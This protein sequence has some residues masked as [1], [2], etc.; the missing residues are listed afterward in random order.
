MSPRASSPK[1][2]FVAEVARSSRTS[3]WR[4]AGTA[5]EDLEAALLDEHVADDAEERR[6]RGRARRRAQHEVAE[7][8]AR[9]A[10]HGGGVMAPVPRERERRTRAREEAGRDDAQP[11]GEQAIAHPQQRARRLAQRGLDED[12]EPALG[13]QLVT[14]REHAPGEALEPPVGRSF[15]EKELAEEVRGDDELEAPEDARAPPA[16]DRPPGSP[17]PPRCRPT[18]SRA[19]PR[20]APAAPD[21]RRPS[22]RREPARAP[23]VPTPAP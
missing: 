2:A 17:A 1:A 22:R 16:R 11:R 5:P 13:E 12:D 8:H 4:P 9:L 21:P 6:R 18:R 19:P 3:G 23:A 14:P 20:S 15:G 7:V 10:R